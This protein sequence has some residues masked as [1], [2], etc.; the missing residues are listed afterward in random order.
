MLVLLC[1]EGIASAGIPRIINF[2][3]RLNDSS[4]SPVNPTS[5]SILITF[6]IYNSTGTK[7][8]G[9]QETVPISNG[10]INFNIGSS[11]T[12]GINTACDFATEHSLEIQVGG[13]PPMS[14]KITLTSA[15]YAFYADHL[16]GLAINTATNHALNVPINDYQSSYG[17]LQSGVNQGLN[18]DL[19]NGYHA[20]QFATFPHPMAFALSTHSHTVGDP[21]TVIGQN[22]YAPTSHY[23]NTCVNSGVYTTGTG[24][25]ACV[26]QGLGD[27]VHVYNQ[28]G[29]TNQGYD[30]CNESIGITSMALCCKIQ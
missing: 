2:Q 24:H 11:V 21:N 12:G 4:G 13:D 18:T 27:C 26:S 15:A 1:A 10:L 8:H 30:G 20:S 22:T 7:C 29:Q 5:G 14:P 3:G 25:N 19:L 23:H 28:Y 17:T 9:V 16:S 6:N